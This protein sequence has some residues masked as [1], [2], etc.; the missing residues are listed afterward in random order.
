MVRTTYNQPQLFNYLFQQP[1]IESWLTI[2]I[3]IGSKNVWVAP[4]SLSIPHINIANNRVQSDDY[5]DDVVEM[6]K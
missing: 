2:D 5:V 3:Q 4:K 1:S 6:E